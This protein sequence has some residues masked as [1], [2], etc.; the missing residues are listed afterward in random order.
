MVKDSPVQPHATGD[1][2]NSNAAQPV[3]KRDILRSLCC[4]LKSKSKGLKNKSSNQSLNT[5]D[6]AQVTGPSFIASQPASIP[7]RINHSAPLSTSAGNTATVPSAGQKSISG[8]FSEDLPKPTIKTHLPDALDLI[9]M[10]QQLVYTQRLIREGRLVIPPET[11]A[12]SATPT[13]EPI[14]E[15]QGNTITESN[16]PRA[17]GE[18]EWMPNE[19][20]RIWIGAQDHIQQ[21]HFC[22]LVK[23]VVAEFVKDD[24]KESATIAEVVIL[25]PILDCDT[26]RTLLNC[27]IAKCKQDINFNSLL[28]QGLVQLI[29]DVSPDYLEHGD[30]VNTLTVLQESLKRL[31]KSSSEQKE[32]AKDKPP[33]ADISASKHTLIQA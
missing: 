14:E 16:T 22:E 24:L 28:F 18:Q 32:L 9:E 3:R 13:T 19:T 2:D 11:A 30:L 29:E 7:M 23:N 25:G 33:S 20:E 21:Y 31:H 26:Y 6:H 27:L 15:S 8:I 1:G 4:I 17:Q 5:Q 12:I 10:T